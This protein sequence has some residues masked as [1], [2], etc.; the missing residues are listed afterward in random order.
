M[1]KRKDIREIHNYVYV[2]RLVWTAKQS[3]FSLKR[4]IFGLVA[5]IGNVLAGVTACK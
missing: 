4:P 2:K 5:K 3:T 1:N